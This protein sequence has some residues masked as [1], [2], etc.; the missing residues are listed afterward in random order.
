MI[1]SLCQELEDI[2]AAVACV[3]SGSSHLVTTR[4]LDRP[5][6]RLGRTN[7]ARVHLNRDT[8]IRV[9]ME[10]RRDVMRRLEDFGIYLDP[11]NTGKDLVG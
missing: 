6:T 11:D 2:E 8:A 4:Y 5:V 10:T 7:E 3:N 1:K 9:L